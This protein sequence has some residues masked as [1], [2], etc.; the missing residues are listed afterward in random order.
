MRKETEAYKNARKDVLDLI[1]EWKGRLEDND[2]HGGLNP[3][4][5]DFAVLPN[6]FFK[7]E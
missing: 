4:E 5:A 6:Y 2:F 7:A 3:D 1:D